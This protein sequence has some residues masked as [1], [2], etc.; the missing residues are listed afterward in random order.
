MLESLLMGRKLDSNTLIDIDFNKHAVGDTLITDRAGN[1]WNRT[2]GSGTNPIVINDPDMGNVMQFNGS[3]YFSLPLTAALSLST[4]SFI[5]EVVMK[6]TADY[7][8]VFGTGDYPSPTGFNLSV[9]H[10]PANYIQVF[11]QVTSSNYYRLYP[12]L[13]YNGS[14]E[15]VTV[16]RVYGSSFSNKVERNGVQ[17]GFDTRGSTVIGNGTGI[18]IA[19]TPGAP[20]TQLF[21]GLIKSIKLTLIK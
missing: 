17:V 16:Q 14:W 13:T 15:K 7:T 18:F 4:K 5:L 11:I 6:P 2:A 10:T 1:N 3:G 8:K 21:K 9:N 12:P 19:T 20:G